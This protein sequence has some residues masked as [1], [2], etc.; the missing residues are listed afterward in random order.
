MRFY[1]FI[2]IFQLRLA[3]TITLWK[4]ENR[5]DWPN[6]HNGFRASVS[7]GFWKVQFVWP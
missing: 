5:F 7:E 4:A 2:R 6:Q 3:K 1:P